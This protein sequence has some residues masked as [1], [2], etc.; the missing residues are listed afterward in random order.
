MLNYSAILN[1]QDNKFSTEVLFLPKKNKKK[2]I[3]KIKGEK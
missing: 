2:N 3:L 1:F